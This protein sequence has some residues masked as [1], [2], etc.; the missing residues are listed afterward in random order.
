MANLTEHQKTLLEVLYAN[1]LEL[2]SENS[3]ALADMAKLTSSAMKLPVAVTVQT[4]L[5]AEARVLRT[6]IEA[7]KE[8][9]P[10]NQYE[11]IEA[12][13]IKIVLGDIKREKK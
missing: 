9:L 5:Q 7:L 8:V 10:S 13:L 1:A 2:S 6:V 11:M 3:K 4:V 12:H